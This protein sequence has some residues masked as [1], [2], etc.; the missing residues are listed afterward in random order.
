MSVECPRCES[1]TTRRIHRTN[2]L[3]HSVMS[4]FGHYPW[5]CLTCQ[6]RFFDAMRSAG[7]KRNPMGE[8]YTSRQHAPKVRPG[9]EE[10]SV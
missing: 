5:E 2:S 7:S 3:T 9:S 1:T 4:F 8:V 10:A 6:T